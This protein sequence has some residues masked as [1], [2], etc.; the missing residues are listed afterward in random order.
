MICSLVGTTC[1]E[2]SA[3]QYRIEDVTKFLTIIRIVP[4]V[5]RDTEIPLKRN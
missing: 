4:D 5:V 3:P 1:I 2:R